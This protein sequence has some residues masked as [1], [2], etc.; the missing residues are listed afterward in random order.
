MHLKFN[1]L[2]RAVHLQ[3][4]LEL[5][6]RKQGAVPL[7]LL[8]VA[9]VAFLIALAS[10]FLPLIGAISWFIASVISLD[11]WNRQR[12]VVAAL[13][14]SDKHPRT[15]MD[16]VITEHGLEFTTKPAPYS[17]ADMSGYG[18]SDDL[19][20]IFQ[21]DN[22]GHVFPRE[23]FATQQDWEHFMELVKRKLVQTHG[24]GSKK[25]G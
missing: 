22:I 11:S 7:S 9:M 25:T 23:H 6:Q 19:V 18:L 2:Q 13:Q 14:M 20:V 4:F 3:R 10:L 15:V 5:S 8:T 21:A 12:K 16:G 17:W 24:K 1:G